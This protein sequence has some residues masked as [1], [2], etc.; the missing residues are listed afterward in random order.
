MLA[1]KSPG[2]IN[3]RSDLMQDMAL[4]TGGQRLLAGAGDSLQS[5]KGV[6]LGRARR[7]WV[8]ED[9]FGIVGAQGDPRQVSAHYAQLA[10]N[11]DQT[12]D[13]TRQK[14][15]RER[16][17]KLAGGSAT[18]WIGGATNSEIEP[19]KEIA[20]R[21]GRTIRSAIG[22]GVLPGGGSA[23]LACRLPLQKRLS[24]ACETEERAAYTMLLQAIE[25]PVRTILLNA[26]YEPG[27]ILAQINGA[28]S[29]YGFD[30]E[31]RRI[32]NMMDAGIVDAANAYT[33]AVQGAITGAAQ[34]MSI[35]VLVHRTKPDYAMNT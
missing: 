15:L 21:T 4:L 23:L 1:V 20:S 24:E 26:G 22:S 35:E 30:V 28:G 29:L 17:E 2:D 6:H 33:R 34:A 14:N 3:T 25:V 31:Q 13:Q 10:R 19:R 11:L 5:V 8:S 18:L 16:I 27:E 9:R 32:V 7:V 12:H